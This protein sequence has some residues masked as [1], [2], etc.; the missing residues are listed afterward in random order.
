[1]LATESQ[2]QAIIQC[3]QDLNVT[4]SDLVLSLLQDTGFEQHLFTV[5]VKLQPLRSAKDM[6]C[7]REYP[8]FFV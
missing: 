6:A 7:S 3:L 8:E 1:M 5:G 4:V 2:L